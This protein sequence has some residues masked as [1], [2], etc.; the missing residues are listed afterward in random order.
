MG[1]WTDTK[2][3]LEQDLIAEINTSYA[4]SIATDYGLL[5]VITIK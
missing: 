4:Q 5:D 3:V 2:E 1:N